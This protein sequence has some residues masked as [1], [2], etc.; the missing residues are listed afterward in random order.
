MLFKLKK[1]PSSVIGSTTDS[2]SV[3]LSSSLNWVTVKQVLPSVLFKEVREM[4]YTMIFLMAFVMSAVGCDVVQ[5]LLT[6]EALVVSGKGMTIT[7]RTSDSS[8]KNENDFPVECVVT[9]GNKL[10]LHRVVIES[11]ET[12]AC[13]IQ[14]GWFLKMYVKG[15]LHCATLMLEDNRDKTEA[16]LNGSLEM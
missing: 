4:K 9:N 11:G 14:H 15:V 12:H 7:Y 2:E 8:V 6:K 10:E 3:S 1:L 13:E 16:F 5:G